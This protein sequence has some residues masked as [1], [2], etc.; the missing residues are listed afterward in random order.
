MRDVANAAACCYADSRAMD[1][2]QRYS[3]VGEDVHR[4]EVP[5]HVE[6]GFTLAGFG[7]RFIAY[8]IDF[9]CMVLFVSILFSA[10]IALL[11]VFQK[12][13][14][15]AMLQGPNPRAEGLMIAILLSIFGLSL[16]LVS[17]FYFVIFEML[18]DGR[19]PGKR[20]MGI[21]VIRDEGGRI[22]FYTSLLRNL[23]R[24][25][26]WLPAFYFA[27]IIAMFANKK[28]KR[29]GDIAAGTVVV[30]EEKTGWMPAV[31]LPPPPPSDPEAGDEQVLP[32]EVL[33]RLGKDYYELCRE[34]LAR[35]DL[36]DPV[37]SDEIAAIIAAE[38]MARLG[39]GPMPP[40]TFIARF[41][42]AW[43]RKNTLNY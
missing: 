42:E 40:E 31:S 41:V 43:K 27:A 26:D 24:V 35:K 9:L 36:I 15:E 3:S 20:A 18:W 28:W 6:I 37:K 30:K 19:S 10:L 7:S 39:L 21:R 17:W 4:V 11:I 5:E 32:A 38:P 33:S 8:L 1:M 34:F 14:F 29:L 13:L 25:A 23:L 12:G 16:F 22:S 2:R